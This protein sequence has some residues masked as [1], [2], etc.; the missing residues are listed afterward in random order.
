MRARMSWGP[1]ALFQ[2][3]PCERMFEITAK[4]ENILRFQQL[5]YMLVEKMPHD[6]SEIERRTGSGARTL[7]VRC[8][9]SSAGW[10]S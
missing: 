4:V 2:S 1:A 10:C 7:L 9:G 5:P 3:K 6:G 8:A